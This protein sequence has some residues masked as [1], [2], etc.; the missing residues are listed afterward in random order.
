MVDN[1]LFFL[2]KNL[3][4]NWFFIL[5]VTTKMIFMILNFISGWFKNNSPHVSFETRGREGAVLYHEGIRSIS[6]Y[7][8]MGG[9]DVVFYLNVPS[10][11]NWKKIT[12]FSSETRDRI[13]TF[14]ARQTQKHQAPSCYFEIKDEVILF[15]SVL[16]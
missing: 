10:E 6:F 16:R 2:C 1:I 9:S 5:L 13:L 11:K 7:M 14:V 8:E 3:T 15:K 4:K 12:G